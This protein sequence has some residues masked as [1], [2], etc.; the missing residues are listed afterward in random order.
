MYECQRAGR[1]IE[2]KELATLAD[3]LGGGIGL[4]NRYT[5]S[6]VRDLVDDIILVSEKEIAEAIRH[7][8]W[9]ERQIVEGSGSVGI[10]ALLTGKV[11]S[12]GPTASVVSGGNV[13][14]EQHFRII[15]GEDVDVSGE[16]A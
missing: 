2:V 6:M 10:A 14:M 1:P 4:D 3:S 8:Y 7:A 5:F 16:A 15:S 9:Q 13:G 11:K 12:R